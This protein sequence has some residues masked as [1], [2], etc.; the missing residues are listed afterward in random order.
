MK[1]NKKRKIIG[2]IIFVL[3]V[4]YWGIVFLMRDK[5]PNWCNLSAGTYDLQSFEF[6]DGGLDS[7]FGPATRDIYGCQGGIFG[8]MDKKN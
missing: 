8:F 5:S 7:T 1:K 4:S 3:I 6:V 2:I